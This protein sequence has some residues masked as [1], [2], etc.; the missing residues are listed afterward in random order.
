M[1]T[2]EKNGI[3]YNVAAF[4][5]SGFSE[6]VLGVYYGNGY[7]EPP[8]QY[9]VCNRHQYGKYSVKEL[10]FYGNKVTESPKFFNVEEPDNYMQVFQRAK[11]CFDYYTREAFWDISI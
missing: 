6:V 11:E 5:Q 9:I 3:E 10:C 1:L 4:F 8:T 7:D 2:F